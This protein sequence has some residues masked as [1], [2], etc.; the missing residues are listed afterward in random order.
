MPKPSLHK[1]QAVLEQQLIET[2]MAGLK[3]W[4]SDLDYPE[5]YSDMQACIRGLLITFEIKRRPLPNPLHLICD[6]CEGLGHL[7]TKAEGNYREPKT[8]EECRG[9]GYTLGS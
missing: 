7:V 3:L 2:A 1:D 6:G 4:R 9:R 5:S 8:C